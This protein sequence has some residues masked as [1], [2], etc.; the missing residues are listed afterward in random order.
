MRPSFQ[1]LRC[2][3]KPHMDL[4]SVSGKPS[5]GHPRKAVLLLNHDWNSATARVAQ[6]DAGCVAA[7][8]HESHGLM[9]A[10]ERRDPAP[11]GQSP[12]HGPP[13]IPW[14]G[15]IERMQIQKLVGE[16][17]GWE[18]LSFYPAPSPDEKW[19]NP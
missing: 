3:R 4:R 5:N 2:F 11:S 1:R 16:F 10:G 13:I 18:N 15:P 17:D 12:I 9:L 19:L 8:G 7:G 6:R 14:S